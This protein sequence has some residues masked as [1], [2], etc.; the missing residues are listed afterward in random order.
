MDKTTDDSGYLAYACGM[1]RRRHSPYSVGSMATAVIGLGW[2]L[3][4]A[5]DMPFG[6]PMWLQNRL[7]SI[8]VGLPWVPA[9][10]GLLLAFIGVFDRDKKA[11]LGIIAAVV[12]I[13]TSIILNPGMP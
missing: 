4:I 2:H 13:C 1:S 11:W 3:Y 7:W 6:G 9:A 5:Y 12:I 10:L 8:A